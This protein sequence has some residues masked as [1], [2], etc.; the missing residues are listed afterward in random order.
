VAGLI[1]AA[2]AGLLVPPPLHVEVGLQPHL[3]QPHLSE[4]P[5]T[6][7]T[8]RVRFGE[9]LQPAQHDR[10]VIHAALAVSESLGDTVEAVVGADGTFVLEG[11]SGPR[12]I[13]V[14]S[15]GT[16]GVQWWFESVLWNGRDIT[17]EPMDFSRE[18]AGELVV[19]MALRPTAIV[20]SVEDVAGIPMTGACVVMLPAD[21]DQQRGW[22]TAVGT[23]T[24]DRRGRFY[25]TGMPPGEYRVE[26]IGEVCPDRIALLDDADV[27]MRRATAVTVGAGKVARIVVTGET[28]S[29]ARW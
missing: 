11:V 15:Q 8:G 10:L 9:S 25:F 18:P 4:S 26:G 23:T 21:P 3:L 1:L 29:A 5:A 28:T 22:S 6:S 24:A 12:I 2:V 7:I 13:R 19:V 16:D 14:A 20:G 27:L 17:N